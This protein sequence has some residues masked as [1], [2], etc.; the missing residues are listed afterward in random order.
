MRKRIFC[1]AAAAVQLFA[2]LGLGVQAAEDGLTDGGASPLLQDAADGASSGYAA[3]LAA[4]AGLP[5][6]VLAG[7]IQAPV[8]A[9]AADSPVTVEVSIPEDGFYTVG[10][11]LPR[12]GGRPRRSG[13]RDSH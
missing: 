4:H 3:Y 11:A 10:V 5:D 7:A 6:A 2:A 8:N 13:H 9:V 1:M 12:R